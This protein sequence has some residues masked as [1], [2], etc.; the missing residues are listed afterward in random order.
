VPVPA[1]NQSV[2][3]LPKKEELPSMNSGPGASH[4]R[5]ISGVTM[6]DHQRRKLFGKKI[7]V[8][9]LNGK[10][11]LIGVQIAALL[12]RETFNMYRSMKIKQIDLVR[13]NPDQVEYFVR[14]GAVRSGTHSVTLV[15]F[16]DAV[17]FI[18]EAQEKQQRTEAGT[19]SKLRKPTLTRTVNL[20]VITDRKGS[21]PL[22]TRV[23][24]VA[25]LQLH[26]RDFDFTSCH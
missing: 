19:F 23:P 9:A 15:P 16:D 10:E 26:R 5:S 11:F 1:G 4:V 13:A 8:V 22:N 25:S 24:S 17:Q 3:V 20:P 21:P 2:P 12:K 6:M 18:S 7:S 14:A